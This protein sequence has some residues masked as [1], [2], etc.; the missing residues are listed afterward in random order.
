MLDPERR[1]LGVIRPTVETIGSKPK[2]KHIGLLATTGN[3]SIGL[4]THWK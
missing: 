4:L 2:A 3:S 1:V